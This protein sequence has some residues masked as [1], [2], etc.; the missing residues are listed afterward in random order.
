MFLLIGHSYSCVYQVKVKVVSKHLLL[1]LSQ[2]GGLFVHYSSIK[3]TLT[4]RALFEDE[5]KRTS[6]TNKSVMSAGRTF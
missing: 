5:D 3:N 6:L 2:S 4:L 1:F